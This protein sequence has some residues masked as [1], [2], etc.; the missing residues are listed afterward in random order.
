MGY[1][2][3]FR[4][5]KHTV[6]VFIVFSLSLFNRVAYAAD[7]KGVERITQQLVSPPSLPL[8]TQ[9][10]RG[11]PKIIQVRLVV[12]EKEIE[13]TK[14]VYV[15]AMTF[16]GSVPGPI[17]VVHQGDYVE[18]TLVNPKTNTL[19]HNI[20]FHAATGGAGGGSLTKVF[21]GEE[22]KF[23]F[24]ATKSGV[25]VYHCAPGG[26]MIPY[27]VVMGM[28]GAIMVLPRQGLSD[29]KGHP[30]RYDEPIT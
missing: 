19:L 16:N 10:A 12:K 15:Q 27:H 20:D 3:F 2:P 29:E 23:R 21:P 25:F 9:I 30:I 6:L 18:L 22:V 28:N 24:K 7:L 17:I 4:C 8:H 1:V 14:G 13:I 26:Q 5:F 11:K